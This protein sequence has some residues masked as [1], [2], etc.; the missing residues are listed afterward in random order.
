MRS[1]LKEPELLDKLQKLHQ[2]AK[3]AGLDKL[4]MSEIDAEVEA[5]RKELK[6][7]QQ[8]VRGPEQ[9]IEL[10]HPGPLVQAIQRK[11]M[12]KQDGKSSAS[13]D[14]GFGDNVLRSVL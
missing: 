1:I 12:A 3:A 11:N 5:T 7:S 9:L 10:P 6:K 2:K 8:H 14:F 4:T 13:E